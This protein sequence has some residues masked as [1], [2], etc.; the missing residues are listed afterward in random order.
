MGVPLDWQ[1]QHC[2]GR[3]QVHQT[4]FAV[5]QPGHGYLPEDGGEPAGVAGLDSTSTVPRRRRKPRLYLPHTARVQVVLEQLAKQPG[6]FDVESALELAVVEPGALVTVQPAQDGLEALTGSRETIGLAAAGW[7]LTVRG[8]RATL[9]CQR[10][11]LAPAVHWQLGSGP[12]RRSLRL[13]Q[14][15]RG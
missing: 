12:T 7:L 2:V 3:V 15:A 11:L 13:P 1:V 8:G 5:G 4:R 9:R 6:S 10:R 14:R